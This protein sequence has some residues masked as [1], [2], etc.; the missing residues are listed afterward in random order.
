MVIVNSL[1]SLYSRVDGNVLL[2]IKKR[3]SWKRLDVL[4]F[5]NKNIFTLQ[6]SFFPFLIVHH[7]D[8]YLKAMS[9]TLWYV[10]MGSRSQ[11]ALIQVINRIMRYSIGGP[12]NMMKSVELPVILV[13]ALLLWYY[14]PSHKLKLRII[15]N[16]PNGTSPL[17]EQLSEQAIC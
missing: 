2:N 3:M 5:A 13:L 15:R 12:G 10:S 16:I 8:K 7:L 17:L 1:D 4:R 11:I 14:R 6:W 9:H